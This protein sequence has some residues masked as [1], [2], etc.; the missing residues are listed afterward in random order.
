MDL[1]RL[2][3]LG[4]PEKRRGTSTK[5]A[6]AY[7]DNHGSFLLT[8]SCFSFGMFFFCR[9]LRPEVALEAQ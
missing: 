3:F 2:F 4:V 7:E 9:F 8:I 1:I 6:N 5:K